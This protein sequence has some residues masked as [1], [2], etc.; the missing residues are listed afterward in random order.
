MS[1]YT[2]TCRVCNIVDSPSVSIPSIRVR[3]LLRR[4]AWASSLPALLLHRSRHLELRLLRSVMPRHDSWD[5]IEGVT[6]HVECVNKCN[7]PFNNGSG[8]IV[9]LI[10]KNSECDCQTQFD[11]NECKLDPKGCSQYTVF[12]VM[13]SK[14]LVFCAN[15]DSRDNVTGAICISKRLMCNPVL[16]HMK[17]TRQTSCVV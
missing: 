1:R 5:K 14:T 8:V 10:A 7:D 4:I 12:S 3:T 9:F 13:D 6:P 2:C 15:K 17:M 16:T 11:E